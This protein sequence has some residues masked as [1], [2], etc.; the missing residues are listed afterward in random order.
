L[1][2]LL[3]KLI[4]KSKVRG[5][6]RLARFAARRLNA[7][8]N[9]PVVVL[10]RKLFL[11]LRLNSAQA[12]FL[13]SGGGG[14]GSEPELEIIKKIV[15]A[16]DTVY[17][18]GAHLGLYA[19]HL[20]EAVGPNGRVFAF[21]PNRQVLPALRR[22]IDGLPNARLFETALS[23]QS[24][25]ETLAVP[26][27]DA[28]MASLKDWTEGRHGKIEFFECETATL[29]EI[30]EKER[31]PQ[32]DFI[33][34]D[35]EGGEYDCFRGGAKSLNRSPDAPLILFEANRNS[36][37]GYGLAVSQAFD[38]LASLTEPQ[39][40]FYLIGADARLEKIDS[41]PAEVGHANILA[42]PRAKAERLA[43]LDLKN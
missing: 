23:H 22:T 29:D 12:L 30:I 33:K 20:V 1:I 32:P 24:K 17:D 3:T 13:Q 40:S 41:I 6:S 14:G 36:A 31:L 38:F 18:I 11:D 16:G 27:G 2:L 34:C 43:A 7:L 19:I 10:S 25:T 5:T 28:T 8:Q 9:V 42:V 26:D 21:E 39:Y 35:I 15:R 4:L 37:R